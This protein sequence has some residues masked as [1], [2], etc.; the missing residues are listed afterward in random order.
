M[1]MK[2][3]ILNIPLQYKAMQYIVG[4][5][6][7]LQEWVSKESLG[8]MQVW[9][10]NK[11][12]NGARSVY[13]F[14][15]PSQKVTPIEEGD[16][17]LIATSGSS[18]VYPT[19]HVVVDELFRKMFAEPPANNEEREMCI[20]DALQICDR[21]IPIK[22]KSWD[23]TKCGV[24]AFVMLL[25]V[26]VASHLPSR[27]KAAVQFDGRSREITTEKQYLLVTPRFI[28]DLDIN[29]HATPYV[30]TWRD[31]RANDWVVAYKKK[32]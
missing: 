5:L 14:S 20:V 26:S 2:E 6:P 8:Q 9:L 15:K 13:I 1:Q 3:V 17:V 7:D 11:M 24:S 23:A 10:T 31:I 21:G 19:Y 27:F 18:G 16:W 25:D 28:N 22:R 32:N 4:S 30:P 12:E 29:W